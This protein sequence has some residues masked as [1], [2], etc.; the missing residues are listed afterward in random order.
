MTRVKPKVKLISLVAIA[1]IPLVWRCRSSAERKGL[2][3][4][5]T[6]YAIY[7]TLEGMCNKNNYRAGLTLRTNRTV[8][9]D[10]HAPL[11]L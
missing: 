8:N 7:G 5:G 11:L 9:V 4:L 3:T 2:L 10:L 1:S 6:Q